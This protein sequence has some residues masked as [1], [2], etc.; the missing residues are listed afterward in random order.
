[1]GLTRAAK[2]AAIGLVA[3]VLLAAPPAMATTDVTGLGDST[4]PLVINP[5]TLPTDALAL[6]LDVG[7]APTVAYIEKMPVTKTI[8]QVSIG[9]FAADQG[10]CS[11]P[12]QVRV[13]VAEHSAANPDDFAQITYSEINPTVPDA[14][15]VLTFT[16]KDEVTLK[17]GLGYSFHI[18]STDPGAC[19]WAYQTTWAHNASVVDGGSNP[20]TGGPYVGESPASQEKRGWHSYGS[21]DGVTGPDGC[22]GTNWSAV[23][24]S[25][26]L[27][28]FP[29]GGAWDVATSWH[30]PDAILPPGFSACRLYPDYMLTNYGAQETDWSAQAN[31]GNI[32]TL[33]DWT[34]FAPPG[35]AV[36]DG[37]YYG[38]PW[39]T[40]RLG[41]PRDVYLKLG[42]DTTPPAVKYRPI[43]KFDTS[44]KWQPL[45]VS[46][47]FA[48]GIHRVCLPKPPFTRATIQSFFHSGNTAAFNRA[49]T[50]Q[51]ITDPAQLLNPPWN[52]PSAWVQVAG[53]GYNA[54]TYHS[55][56]P[57]CNAAGLLDCGLAPKSSI[58]YN[59]TRPSN[60]YEYLDYWVFYRYNDGPSY[61]NGTPVD[62]HQADWEGVTV[63]VPSP[64]AGTFDFAAF[65]QHK[66]VYSYLRNNLG[67]D[68]G[69]TGSCGTASAPKGE[70]LN[71]YVVNGGH[72]SYPEPCHARVI[73][74]YNVSCWET[75]FPLLV[76]GQNFPLLDAGG[77]DGSDPWPANADSTAVLPLAD[78]AAPWVQWLG[79]WGIEGNVP[80]LRN[81]ARFRS[82]GG[83]TNACG[84]GDG[85]RPD[86]VQICAARHRRV[87]CASWFGQS[88][89]VA[90]CDPPRLERAMRTRTL[91]RRGTLRIVFTRRSVRSAS[92]PGVVQAMGAVVTPRDRTYVK[93]VVR[94][95][96]TVLVRGFVPGQVVT[97]KF[98]PTRDLKNPSIRVTSSHGRAVVR[99]VAG[100]RSL[101]PVAAPAAAV[102]R[103]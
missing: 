90:A 3:S 56:D 65:A 28:S 42:E 4:S 49:T 52:S 97:A 37:W 53:P 13:S 86:P 58:Y 48:E 23:M 101:K 50:C 78:A 74:G 54:S 22:A 95:G 40:E 64:N 77:W 81:Q 47:F 34:Q 15:G 88:V 33:C 60:S 19:R 45:S 57:S 99:L 20:C 38:L 39:R 6:R 67:C 17:A 72:A 44:E 66:S 80:N 82:P 26:W 31:D 68:D 29:S 46:G 9:D 61:P 73:L 5:K 16:L 30:T 51:V 24:P 25:G 10:D 92:A 76:A 63:G 35:Q 36:A 103:R 14:P 87:S 79:T 69:P 1:V 96:S 21:P 27:V 55:P 62:K 89:S 2:H 84:S 93:G 41:R 94:A 43:L 18:Q 11:N 12:M 8:K 102:R 71:V 83:A 85:T 91:G 7:S 100:G 59:E 70:R 75:G 98:K 32:H